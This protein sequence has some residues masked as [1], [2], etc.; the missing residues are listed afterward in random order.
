LVAYKEKLLEVK[1]EI[2]QNGGQSICF[3]MRPMTWKIDAVSKQILADV[4]HIDI[5]INNAGRSI[6]RAVHESLIVSMTLNAPCSS[7]TLAQYV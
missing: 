7:T 6:R 4:D 2:E 5:L 3:S 1:A